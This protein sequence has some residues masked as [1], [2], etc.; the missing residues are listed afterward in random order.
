MSKAAM[1]RPGKKG[2]Q[3]EGRAAF[4]RLKM[5]SAPLKSIGQCGRR[6]VWVEMTGGEVRRQQRGQIT[7][8]FLRNS[9][10]CSGFKRK[11]LEVWAKGSMDLKRIIMVATSEKSAVGIP[12]RKETFV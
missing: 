3:A 6:V 8:P 5:C 2:L 4:L 10:F 9:G 7:G 12:N 1:G 11:P